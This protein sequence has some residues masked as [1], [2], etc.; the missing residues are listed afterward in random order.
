M[1]KRQADFKIIGTD[2]RL[3]VGEKDGNIAV[4]YMNIGEEPAKEAV[5]RLSIF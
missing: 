1:I 5:V 4:T 3:A 2:A